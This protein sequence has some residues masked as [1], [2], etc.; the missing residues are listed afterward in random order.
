MSKK[1]NFFNGVFYLMSKQSPIGVFDSGFGGLSVLRKLTETIP[2]YD[3]C[4]LGDNA[5]APYGTRSFSTVYRYTRE[6]VM[7][8]F[9]R[10]CHLVIIACNTA[11]AKALRSIQQNDLPIVAPE[12]RVLGV[13]RPLTEIAGV[14]SHNKHIG[15]LA[16]PGT[17]RS[18]SYSIE[19]HKFFPDVHLTQEACP[20][21]VPLVE[22]MEV[23]NSGTAYF[24][25]SHIDNLFTADPLIDTVILGCTHYP[26]LLPVIKRYVPGN[27]KIV[28][29]GNIVADSLVAYLSRHPE[30][31]QKCTKGGTRQF[32]TTESPEF[33]DTPASYFFGS[34]VK[35]EQIA[36]S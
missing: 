31:A 11:S 1:G 33:F 7:W 27:V 2:E 32:Y 21:W 4:Y 17:V 6:A 19:I 18:A 8:L 22:N 20:L 28:S 3:F 16:T 35:S 23:D 25:K 5:R 13:I 29:Q 34:E 15:L 30:I 9:S 12:K 14:I 26:F 10:N 36:I 24:V